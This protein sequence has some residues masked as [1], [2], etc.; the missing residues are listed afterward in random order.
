MRQNCDHVL[1][2]GYDGWAFKPIN[3]L[4][5]MLEIEQLRGAMKINKE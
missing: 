5:R 2:A 1:Q 4:A 3:A